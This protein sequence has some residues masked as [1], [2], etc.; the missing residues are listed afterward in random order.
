MKRESDNIPCPRH[1]LGH[2]WHSNGAVGFTG[3]YESRTP[4]R[5][6]HCGGTAIQVDVSKPSRIE[7]YALTAAPTAD[8]EAKQ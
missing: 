6:C 1:S 8:I 7:C 3:K 4:V 2:C 5:C